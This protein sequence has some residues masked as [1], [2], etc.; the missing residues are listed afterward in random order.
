MHDD[1][2]QLDLASPTTQAPAPTPR[3]RRRV[4]FG[5]SALPVDPTARKYEKRGRLW[6]VV[7]YFLCPCHLPLTLAL[8]GGS[9]GGTAVGSWVMGH[10]VWAGVMLTALYGLVLWAGFRTIHRAKKIEAGMATACA[11]DRCN[12]GRRPG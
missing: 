1:V 2:I 9:I 5:D 12:P 10:K 11:T 7:S 4:F 3:S 6:L 8:V